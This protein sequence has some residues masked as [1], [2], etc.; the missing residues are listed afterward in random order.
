MRIDGDVVIENDTI[1]SGGEIRLF[2]CGETLKDLVARGARVVLMCHIGRPR[3]KK[4]EDL[5]VKPVAHKLSE[6]L[7]MPIKVMNDIVGADVLAAV[8]AMRNGEIVFLENLRFDRREEANDDDFS[9]ELA[10]L[11][12]IYV[13]ESFANSHRSHA[14]MLGITKFLPSYAGLHLTREVTVL[15]KVMEQPKRPVVAAISGAKIETKASLLKNLLPQVDQLITG[16]GVANMFIQAQGSQ[17]GNSISEPA[18]LSFVKD[19]L[20][21]YAEKIHVPH[22][23]RVLRKDKKTGDE[24][25]LTLASGTVTSD[26]SIYDIGPETSQ[27]YAK[28]VARAGTCVWNGPMGKTELSDF[29]EGTR[30]L[31]IAIR[32]AHVYTVVGGG[33]TVSA[34]YKMNLIKGF[35]HVSTGGGAMIALLQGDKLPAIEVLCS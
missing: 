13:N 17:I 25:V 31:A 7:G 33:D 32:D 8:S 10:G 4:V 28:I 19:L 35:D 26:D 6:Y 24:K 29:M 23:V 3:G 11:A 12:E 27:D 21:E 9:K 5:S 18:M 1:E 2:S 34:L 30:E 14:S 22:D 20:K 15:E 16:G